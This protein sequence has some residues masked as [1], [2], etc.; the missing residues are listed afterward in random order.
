MNYLAVFMSFTDK[1][2]PA[3]S[4]MARTKTARTTE[5]ALAVWTA[6]VEIGRHKY[7]E[8]DDDPEP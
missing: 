7:D 1:W 5:K 3:V 4:T 2:N 6:P 8:E